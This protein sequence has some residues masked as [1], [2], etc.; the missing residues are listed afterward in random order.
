[1]DDET[2]EKYRKA[3]AIAGRAREY[4]A[5]LIAPGV[6]LIDV[7]T[8]VEAFVKREGAEPAFPCCLSL[9]EDAAHYTPAPHDDRVFARGD[10]VKLD[11]GAHV[12]GYIGD[13]AMTIEVGG[14]EANKDLLDAARA[15]LAGAL[16]HVVAGGKIGAIGESVER[17]IRGRGFAPIANLTGHSVDHYHQH[18][19]LSIPNVAGAARGNF[20]D[21]IAVAVEPF[22][23]RG[24]GR[25]KD[26]GP[27]HIFHFHASRPQ[28]DPH[29]KAALKFIE[30]NHPDL[31]FAERWVAAA[32]PENKITYAM[33]LLER[34]GAVTQYP[35][36]REAADGLVAQFEHTLLIHGGKVEITTLPPY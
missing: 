12:D 25:V 31:P 28:R 4:G 9:N 13:T 2:A 3:G 14:T 19:G 5:T 22:A 32:I 18:A 21:S 11:V 16:P 30:T 34:S 23:T 20:P 10:L 35:I 17:T 33:R 8:A 29:A 24:E 36:L 26:S 6:K 15:A 7:S 1:M 27:G